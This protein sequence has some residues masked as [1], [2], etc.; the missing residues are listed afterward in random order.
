M[1]RSLLRRLFS[2][3]KLKEKSIEWQKNREKVIAEKLVKVDCTPYVAVSA[4]A[5]SSV[6]ITIRAWTRS[7]FFWDVYFSVNE[8]IYKEFPL[9]GLNFPF[10]QMDVHLQHN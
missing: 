1:R 5:D 4:L 10:P 6:N 2:H 9:H 3:D 8:K 7:E